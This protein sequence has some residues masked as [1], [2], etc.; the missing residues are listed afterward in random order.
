MTSEQTTI[1][2]I[3]DE[4]AVRLSIAYYLEDLGFNVITAENGKIGVN[5]FNSEKVDLVL[6]DLRMPE[7]DGLE[8][9]ENIS[10]ANSE[11]PLIVVSGTGVISDALEALHQGAWDYVLKP[12]IDFSVLM[13]SIE[14]NLEKARLKKENLRYQHHLEDMVAERTSE[15][16]KANEKLTRNEQQ[17]RAILD[18]IKIG[19]TI[20]DIETR[21]IAYVNPTTA[22]MVG[23][24]IEEL[25]GQK[26]HVTMCP[27]REN[28]CKVLDL[29]LDI[30]S[31]EQ[32]LKTRSE[33]E[34]PIIKTVT[35]ILFQGRDCLLESFQDLRIQK[36]AMAEKELLEKQLRHV[37]RI[38]AIGTLAGGIAHDF[39]NILS[40]ILGNTQLAIMEASEKKQKTA[41]MYQVQKAGQRAAD[42]VKQILTI[43]RQ[44]ELEKK[45]VYISLI[46]KDVVKMLRATLPATI[47]IVSNI[48]KNTGM[49][50]ADPTQIH[51]ILMNLA[52]NAAHA[53]SRSGGVLSLEL[54]NSTINDPVVYMDSSLRPGAYVELVVSDTG[55]GMDQL[56]MDRIFDPYYTTKSM[57][58]GTGLGLAVVMGIVKN[59]GGAI[60]VESEPGKGSRFDLLFPRADNVRQPEQFKPSPVILPRG[61]E[62]VLIVDDEEQIA[63]IGKDM[64][65]RLGYQVHIETNSTE[66]LKILEKNPEQYDLVISDVTMPKMPGDEL[67]EK[68][69]KIRPDIRI[70]LC[71]GYTTRITE[72]EARS[73]GIREYL[74]KPIQLEPLATAVRRALDG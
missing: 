64:L 62:R 26:C 7:M 67:A 51:Q 45:P 10:R 36:E 25:I 60:M 61:S 52:T 57:D 53:M 19:I 55:H 46:M 5:K 31:A 29:G 41:H 71:S 66:A 2:V 16:E 59:C 47:E 8:V 58:E 15:F 28:N 56:T 44:G 14:T 1:L 30:N 17:F 20:I 39:N 32:V 54:K 48:E 72:K 65:T 38:E 6:V 40:V 4:D 34:I 18:N 63:T 21:K 33:N 68:L 11:I 35:R 70:I 3:D 24:P 73:M 50:M 69:L 37:Q 27:C 12:I 74:I 43:S 13:H 9:L 42:L 49:T 22:E 23:Y